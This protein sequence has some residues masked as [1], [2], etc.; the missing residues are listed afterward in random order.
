MLTKT[1]LKKISN[2]IDGRLE[3]KLEEKLETKLNEKFRIFTNYFYT[4]EEIDEKFYNKQE[5]AGKFS[6]ILTAI[7]GIA[8][9]TLTH[10]QEM[11]ALGYRIDKTE[12]WITKA[13]PKIGLAFKH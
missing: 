3:I 11:A 12:K 13:A 1:D 2:L 5:M 6:Q 10:Q 9:N 8:K 4:K 7:D